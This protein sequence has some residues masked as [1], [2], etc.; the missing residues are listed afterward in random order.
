MESNEDEEGGSSKENRFPKPVL[1]VHSC[2]QPNRISCAICN[3]TVLTKIA[4]R[5]SISG[6]QSKTKFKSNAVLWE[7]YDHVYASVYSKVDWN[8][9]KLYGC[10]EC[11]SMFGNTKYRE[12]Q[13]KIEPRDNQEN[14]QQDDPPDIAEIPKETHQTRTTRQSMQCTKPPSKKN[15]NCEICKKTKYDKKGHKIPVTLLTYRNK[16]E[17]LHKAEKALL[18]FAS[19]HKDNGTRY[20]EAAQRIL[21]TK[22]TRSL[23]NA[24]VAYH[25]QPCYSNF[26]CP[27]WKRKFE[28]KLESEKVEEPML[29]EFMDLV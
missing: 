6:I 28:T 18:E 2:D 24:D 9:E 12:A 25:R 5:S 7:Q 17:K 20:S 23:F 22:T 14:L 19:I 4:K 29:E 10:K 15:P 3:L 8:A 16:N 27:S 11:K 26:T 21:L 13:S 1:K